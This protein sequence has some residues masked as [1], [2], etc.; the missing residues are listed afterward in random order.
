MVFQWPSAPQQKHMGVEKARCWLHCA[1]DRPHQAVYLFC[2]RVEQMPE[3]SPP[4]TIGGCGSRCWPAMCALRCCLTT[5]ARRCKVHSVV[6]NRAVH[7]P[8]LLPSKPRLTTNSCWAA[9]AQDSPG[10][11]IEPR[12]ACCLLPAAAHPQWHQLLS[13]LTFH[14]RARS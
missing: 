5:S 2:R 7:G 14:Y 3:Q 10:R 6:L 4:A 1:A 13:A 12:G 11:Q 9:A 8:V